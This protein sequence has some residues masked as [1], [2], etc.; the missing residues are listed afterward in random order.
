VVRAAEEGPPIAG[1]ERLPARA[2]MRA[3]RDLPLPTLERL[4]T[5][6]DRNLRRSSV[7]RAITRAIDKLRT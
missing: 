7:L 1:Y 4:H 5:W 6:E 3:L 2:A